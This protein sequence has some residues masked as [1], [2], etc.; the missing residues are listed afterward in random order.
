MGKRKIDSFKQEEN[1]EKKITL[2]NEA[3]KCFLSGLEG[4]FDQGLKA[5]V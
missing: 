4:A 5:N 2:L 3:E 1:T